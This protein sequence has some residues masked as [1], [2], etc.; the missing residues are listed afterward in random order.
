M[1]TTGTPSAGQTITGPER[2]AS[3]DRRRRGSTPSTRP[4]LPRIDALDGLRGAAVLAVLAFHGGYLDG[5]YLGVDLFFVLSGFLITSL[6][7]DEAGRT[8]GVGLAEFWARRCRRLLPALFA[9]VV[10]VSIGSRW[11]ADPLQWRAIRGDGLAALAYAANWHSILTGGGYGAGTGG[12]SPYEHM[13]SLGIEEQFY[14]VWPLVVALVARRR[15]GRGRA[16]NGSTAS[17][18]L[19]IAVGVAAWSAAWGIVGDSL[20]SWTMTS[21][22]GT[23]VRIAGVA[24]G[25]AIAARRVERRSRGLGPPD[26]SLT[27]TVGFAGL[28]VLAA[29][30]A[31]LD[32]GSPWLFRGGLFACSLAGGAVVWALAS[33]P[34][35]WPARLFEGRVLRQAGLISY[36][37]YL[38]HWPIFVWLDPLRTGLDGIALFALRLLVTVAAAS[39][40]YSLVEQPVR[41]WRTDPLT[42]FLASL[43][44]LAVAATAVW[45]G[46]LGA[47][48]PL[49]FR[50]DGS[51]MTLADHLPTGTQV[52]VLG[53]SVAENLAREGI[54]PL[55]RDLDVSVRNGG[56]WGCQL[57]AGAPLRDGYGKRLTTAAASPCFREYRKRLG[58]MAPPADAVVVFFGG[59]PYDAQL[60]GRWEVPCSPA[61]LSAYRAQAADAVAQ[62]GSGGQPV[63][64]VL[65]ERRA[66]DIVARTTGFDD[67][68]ARHRCLAPVLA[69][70]AR[71]AGAGVVDLA[72]EC[73][74]GCGGVGRDL[75]RDGIHYQGTAAEDVARWLVP[76]ALDRARPLR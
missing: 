34:G 37:L 58:A 9:V 42:T 44:G 73:E 5:G 30:W 66:G 48:A 53:D 75:R 19:T 23:H 47:P 10:V 24:V 8:G 39:V 52:A 46:A 4:G 15:R 71:T 51:F 55:Q 3:A 18:V 16:A 57:M 62:A 76:L 45:L 56:V 22:L 27:E 49:S 38:W 29:A 61:Y 67:V 68:A 7:L 40:S 59:A 28:A 70:V 54:R 35:T 31:L 43:A 26:R 72:E 17:A 21:Y 25:A 20:G 60:A 13:W 64:V 69:E 2:P 65:P 36:G 1:G 50:E 33:R 74:Q 12:R 14:L 11:L 6:L 32:L 63:T 41:R